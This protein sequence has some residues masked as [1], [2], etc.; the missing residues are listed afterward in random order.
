MSSAEIMN[1]PAL[2]KYESAESRDKSSARM[3]NAAENMENGNSC[4]KFRNGHE[5]ARR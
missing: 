1:Q 3:N 5:K 2:Q 4:S